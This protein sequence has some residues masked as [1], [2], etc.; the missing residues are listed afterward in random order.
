HGPG[1]PR[2]G[3]LGDELLQRGGAG[4][5][6][7]RQLLHG[8]R[9]DVVGHALVAAPH[10]PAHEVGSHAAEADHSELHSPIPPSPLVFACSATAAPQ[11]LGRSQSLI[12]PRMPAALSTMVALGPRSASMCSEFPPPT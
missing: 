5:A 12:P 3:G 11:R 10:E 7:A 6:L 8:C 4:R 1:C 2:R 9:I